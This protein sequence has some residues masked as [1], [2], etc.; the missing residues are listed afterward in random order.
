MANNN[1]G[2]KRLVIGAAHY[3]TR[4][5][6]AQRAT[7]V[8]MAVYTVILL[9]SFFTATNFSYQGWAGLFSHHWFKVA[10]FVA[11]LALFYHA[12]V[13]VR[14]IW[15]GFA[16]EKDG[17][18]FNATLDHGVLSAW[19]C[20]KQHPDGRNDTKVEVW[21]VP[22]AWEGEPNAVPDHEDVGK[23]GA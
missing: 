12:W 9:V 5:W 3:G 16:D 11:F 2:P 19:C 13:G 6:L 8:V 18:K 4:D 15:A 21:K 10:T 1:I 14:D 23:C 20:L 17:A 7:A 22:Y